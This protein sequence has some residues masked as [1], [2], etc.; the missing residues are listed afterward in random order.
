MAKAVALGYGLGS[1]TQLPSNCL[2][3]LVVDRERNPITQ[4]AYRLH[5]N[6]IIG[7]GSHSVLPSFSKERVAQSKARGRADSRLGNCLERYPQRH[8]QIGAD[9]T[10][11]L[12]LA[13][14]EVDFS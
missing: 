8:W 10:F 6:V 11:E 12:K 2:C 5:R 4:L 3:I 13:A 14:I 9:G 7:L 1:E